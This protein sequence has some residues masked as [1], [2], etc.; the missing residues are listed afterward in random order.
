MERAAAGGLGKTVKR[1]ASAR[2]VSDRV[3]ARA[4]HHDAPAERREQHLEHVAR[5]VV[6]VDDEHPRRTAEP[7][8]VLRVRWLSS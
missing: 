3:D 7:E 4:C 1:C 5:V 6:V 2:W 8:R